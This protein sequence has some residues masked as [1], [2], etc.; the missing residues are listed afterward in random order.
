M[1]YTIAPGWEAYYDEPDKE[2]RIEIFE[3]LIEELPDDGFNAFRKEVHE[4][5]YPNPGKRGTQMDMFLLDIVYFPGM[6][7]KKIMVFGRTKKEIERSCRDLCLD[8][9]AALSEEEKSIL[10]W[11]IHNAADLYFST[12]RDAGYG[13]KFFGIMQASDEERMAQACREAWILTK[14]IP[15]L[16]DKVED[17]QIFSDAV[18]DAYYHFDR[19]AEKR[20]REYE[21]M[22]KQRMSSGKQGWFGK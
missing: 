10:Y 16:G 20:F 1:M 14:G 7:A 3:R 11:E 15:V 4:K 9:T 6:Y 22:Q 8:R 12:C 13:R 21:E 18:L 2:E 5:R 17:M 19:K